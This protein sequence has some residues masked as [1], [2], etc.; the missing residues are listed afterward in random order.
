MEKVIIDNKTVPVEDTKV[1]FGF[2]AI[3]KPTPEL[4]KKIFRIVLYVAALG[5]IIVDIFPEIPLE[6]KGM[7]AMYSVKA[8]AL[9]HAI[10]K[11]FGLEEVK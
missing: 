1:K 9:V 3:T 6:V 5:N 4:A 7:I 2:A 8:V 11:L 10:T